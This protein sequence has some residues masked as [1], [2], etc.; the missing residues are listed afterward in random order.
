[1]IGAYVIEAWEIGKER[2][3]GMDRKDINNIVEN[4]IK[5]YCKENG[6][7]AEI[8][9]NTHLIGSERIMDSMGLISVVVDI[10]TAFL[11]EGTTVSLTSET[12][13]SSRISPFRSV[14]A[15]CSFIE[16]QLEE[17]K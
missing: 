5:D 10:E 7:A 17:Q 9:Q 8:N 13:M 16:R 12:A 15:L 4:V 14:G 1:M 11:D 2:L 3:R 6:I